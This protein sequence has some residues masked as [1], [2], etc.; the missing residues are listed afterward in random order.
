MDRVPHTMSV[1]GTG[2]LLSMCAH[3]YVPDPRRLMR[4]WRETMVATGDRRDR[5]ASMLLASIELPTCKT[6]IEMTILLAIFMLRRVFLWSEDQFQCELDR[7]RPTDLIKRTQGTPS[8]VV[9][10][11]TAAQ[12]LKRPAELRLIVDVGHRGGKVGVVDNIEHLRPEL[13]SKR[14]GKWKIA[15][16]REIPL[17]RTESAQC[18]SAQVSL[19]KG[20]AVAVGRRRNKGCRVESFSAR[21][22]HAK[23]DL[24]LAAAQIE[25]L[26]RHNIGADQSETA[27]ERGEGRF[28]IVKSHRRRRSS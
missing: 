18:I 16:N 9:S 8:R 17:R 20:V 24:A 11:Q 7:S 22:G 26:A 25:G 10:A 2:G 28:T 6:R 4:T 14:L 23:H 27:K 12:H 19:A 13:K 5:R 3:Q 21:A 15:M 1:P